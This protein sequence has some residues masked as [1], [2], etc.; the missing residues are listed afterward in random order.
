MAI[1]S[2]SG[3]SH[4]GQGYFT[5][6]TNTQDATYTIERWKKRRTNNK[7]G[8]GLASSARRGICDTFLA[9]CDSVSVTSVY[10]KNPTQLPGTLTRP[11]AFAKPVSGSTGHSSSPS[12]R[13]SP[14]FCWL[15]SPVLRI[16][17]PS[18]SSGL[19]GNLARKPFVWV[20]RQNRQKDPLAGTHPNPQKTNATYRATGYM[21]CMWIVCW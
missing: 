9:F 4:L 8:L 14:D 5:F 12:S 15:L 2:F 10:S 6:F 11:L 3:L 16:C 18:F 17:L 13:P 20:S 1:R 7:H 21:I 19:V